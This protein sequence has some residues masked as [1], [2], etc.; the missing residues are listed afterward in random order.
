[1]AFAGLKTII[2]LSFVR[3]ASTRHTTRLSVPLTLF[4][5][6]RHRVSP[7]HSLRRAVEDLLH[8]PRRSHLC[9]SACAELAMQPGR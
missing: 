8:F 3:P 4:V 7:C 2:A 6:P 9:L 5:G 1:M